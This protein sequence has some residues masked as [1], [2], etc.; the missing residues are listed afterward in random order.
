MLK[1]CT[2][3]VQRSEIGMLAMA[4][5]F[6]F[7]ADLT[8]RLIRK[9]RK[10]Y[11]RR[12][13]KRYFRRVMRQ[14]EQSVFEVA[15]CEHVLAYDLHVRELGEGNPCGICHEPINGVIRHGISW[16]IMHW[17]YFSSCVDQ[18]SPAAVPT[19]FSPTHSTLPC[20]YLD[21]RRGCLP[22]P[23]QSTLHIHYTHHATN[24]SLSLLAAVCCDHHKNH[25]HPSL[26]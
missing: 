9:G 15:L 16:E 5:A 22:T 10:A 21:H 14:R 11:S 6:S 19:T 7:H 3:R 1:L 26:V 2:L 25:L 23:M 13:D 17:G 24:Y 18:V 4:E 8:A 12:G 20:T